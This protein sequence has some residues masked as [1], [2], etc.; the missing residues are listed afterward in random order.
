MPIYEYACGDCGDFTA[1][2]PMAESASPQDC[3]RCGERAPRVLSVTAVGHGRGR[4]RRGVPEPK[5]V[6]HQRE[7]A[8]PKPIAA[9]GHDRPWMLGH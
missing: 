5:L 4:R 6:S 3:P 7:P 8:K 9:H 1:S 2:R